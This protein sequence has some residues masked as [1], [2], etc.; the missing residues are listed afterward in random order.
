MSATQ[1]FQE[2]DRLGDVVDRHRRRVGLELG[3]HLADA[4]DH[5][6]PVLHADPHVGQHLLQRLH[7]L[8]ASCRVLDALDVDVDEAFARAP[9]LPAWLRAGGASELAGLASRSTASTG[10]TTRRTSSPRSVSSPITESTRNGMSSLTISITETALSARRREPA[11]TRSGFSARR[12]CASHKNA[13]A[14]RGQRREL[15]RLVATRSSGAARPNSSAAN[16]SGMS[17]AQPGRIVPAASMRV[18][19]AFL[20]RCRQGLVGS[21]VPRS[22][23]FRR[24]RTL[25]DPGR[26]RREGDSL[27]GCSRHAKKDVM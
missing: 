5:R 7:D 9:S 11:A 3:D 22:F 14:S 23:A 12:A 4:A 2:L 17:L 19:G 15:A 8:G 21:C 25:H 10:C 16:P 24:G 27:V 13:Q 20:R 6:P 1:P 18:R 26:Q